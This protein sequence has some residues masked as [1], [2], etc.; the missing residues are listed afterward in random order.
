MAI[1]EYNDCISLKK[2]KS[3]QCYNSYTHMPNGAHIMKRDMNLN[4]LH[5][6]NNGQCPVK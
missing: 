2:R 4:R 5:N 1:F 6:Q 3:E